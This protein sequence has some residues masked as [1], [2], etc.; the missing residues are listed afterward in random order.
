MMA[1]ALVTLP[2]SHATSKRAA[3]A[4]PAGE[5]MCGSSRQPCCCSHC[6]DSAL[7]R[8]EKSQSKKALQL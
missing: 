1:L 4:P 2:Q 7:K 8:C 6:V 3:V 5:T